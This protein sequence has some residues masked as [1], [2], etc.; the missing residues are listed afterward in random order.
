MREELPKLRTEA[1]RAAMLANIIC[2]AFGNYMGAATVQASR[3]ASSRC[4][5]SSHSAHVA[6]GSNEVLAAG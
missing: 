4:S 2:E 6:S 3:Q 1:D 5:A